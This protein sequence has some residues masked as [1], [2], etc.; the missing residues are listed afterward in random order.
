MRVARANKYHHLGGS[1]LVTLLQYHMDEWLLMPVECGH[2][3]H[4][5]SFRFVTQA[6][7]RLLP[8]WSLSLC[9]VDPKT[10]VS[11]RLPSSKTPALAYHLVATA[12]LK[13]CQTPS[14]SFCG[15]GLPL[16]FCILGLLPVRATQLAA[17]SIQADG[18]QQNI[19]CKTI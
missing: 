16:A 15:S 18:A 3:A 12:Q 17:D 7:H 8:D 5:K 1:D 10:T 13:E 19:N 9:T 2:A 6:C 4:S 11:P 14:L